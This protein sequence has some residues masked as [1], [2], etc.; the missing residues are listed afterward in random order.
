MLSVEDVHCICDGI[1]PS[2]KCFLWPKMLCEPA[3]GYYPAVR[4]VEYGGR[5]IRISRVVLEKKLGRSLKPRHLA[6][7]TCDYSPCIN[8]DHLYEGTRKD[9]VRD[10]IERN[11]E[12]WRYNRE[13]VTASVTNRLQND[14]TFREDL[15]A[16]L[17]RGNETF[18]NRYFNDPE[19][20]AKILAGLKRGWEGY[21]RTDKKI[22]E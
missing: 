11:P 3:Q 5:Q 13:A 21:R 20:Q 9:N 18:R 19:F 7:H 15:I 8:Q 16:N 6:L 22:E 12:G 10:M 14:P 2:E 1:E 17:R 4:L